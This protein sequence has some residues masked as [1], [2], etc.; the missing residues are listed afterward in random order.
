MLTSKSYVIYGYFLQA[1]RAEWMHGRSKWDRYL[2]KWGCIGNNTQKYCALLMPR[3]LCSCLYIPRNTE[4]PVFQ[5]W[6]NTAG[7]K[8]FFFLNK[9]LIFKRCFFVLN[10][11]NKT[12]F[13]IGDVIKI[14][15]PISRFPIRFDSNSQEIENRGAL[16]FLFL[17][18]KLL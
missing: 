6:R 3:R 15:T 9:I 14:W 5:Q 17:Y 8:I 4:H 18:W 11:I 12:T 7:I 10:N 16:L 13:N 2:W 1:V